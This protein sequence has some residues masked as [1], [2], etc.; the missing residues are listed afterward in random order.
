MREDE[1][2]DEAASSAFDLIRPPKLLSPL[3]LASPHSGCDYPP[4]FLDLARLDHA[5]LRLSEDCYVDE[6]V[7]GAPAHGVPLLKALFP[8]TYVD[9]NREA[10]ELDP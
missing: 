7:A 10:L 8:R 9:A 6:L 5:T 4:A 1:A 2:A 3:V